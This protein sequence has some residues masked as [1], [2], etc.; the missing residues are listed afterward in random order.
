MTQ[1]LSNVS[2]IGCLNPGKGGGGGD[3]RREYPYKKVGDAPRL[4]CF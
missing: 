4:T 2:R 3:G 1:A